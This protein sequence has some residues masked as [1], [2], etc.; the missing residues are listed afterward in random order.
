MRRPQRALLLSTLISS[1]ASGNWIN[2]RSSGPIAKDVPL[3]IYRNHQGVGCLNH[4]SLSITSS[5][6]ICSRKAN[7]PSLKQSLHLM[8]R[9]C[10]RN[11][12]RGDFTPQSMLE[13]SLLIT[14][15][16]RSSISVYLASMQGMLWMGFNSKFKFSLGAELY[17]QQQKAQLNK[18][19]QRKWR[20]LSRDDCRQSR[21]QAAKNWA[22]A[23]S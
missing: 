10:F 2:L 17:P 19:W 7:R 8:H 20:V 22:T 21:E 13:W 16:T 3:G 18:F 23:P 1:V 6:G 5:R 4:I 11:S 9:D 12:G 15:I 14:R